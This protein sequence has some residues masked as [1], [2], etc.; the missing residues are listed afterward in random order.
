MNHTEFITKV[1]Y[2]IQFKL[3]LLIA[4]GTYGS[5]S[6]GITMQVVNWNAVL[7]TQNNIDVLVNVD[8]AAYL[9][10]VR[11]TIYLY[12]LFTVKF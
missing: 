9:V 1:T 3:N 2:L 11:R 4:F 10:L 12:Y 8:S 5:S 7:G 6:D